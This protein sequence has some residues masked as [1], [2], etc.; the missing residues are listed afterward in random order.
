MP[1]NPAERPQ[2][3]TA[4]SIRAFAEAANSR[5]FSSLRFG[6]EPAS[7]EPFALGEIE[8]TIKSVSPSMLSVVIPPTR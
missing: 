4:I 6:Q 1:G 2:P 8:K 7:I 3:P 5:T